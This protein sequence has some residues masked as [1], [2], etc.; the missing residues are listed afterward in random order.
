M[1]ISPNRHIF[2]STGNQVFFA[3]NM[4]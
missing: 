2:F 3:T 4:P 1:N